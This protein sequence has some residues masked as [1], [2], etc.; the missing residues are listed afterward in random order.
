[1]T[2]TM[3]TFKYDGDSLMTFSSL[4]CSGKN[5][6][7]QL[8]VTLDEMYDGGTRKLGLQKNVICEKCEGRIHSFI[9]S[10]IHSYEILGSRYEPKKTRLIFIGQVMVVRREPWRSVS[11]VKEEA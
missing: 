1:M 3:N 2:F 11:A 7:H 5:V 9:H 6:V 10:F 4:L 8:S